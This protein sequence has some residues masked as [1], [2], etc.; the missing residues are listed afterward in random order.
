M[1]KEITL[2]QLLAVAVTV[3]ISFGTG[4]I[5]LTNKVSEQGAKFDIQ[6]KQ[7]K[8]EQAAIQARFDRFTE[9][10]ELKIDKVNDNVN[11]VLIQM[12][13]KLDRQ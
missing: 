1:K 10:L 4:W 12:E 7:I 9:R 6:I 8:E 13:N 2:G 11:S 5:T 3:L